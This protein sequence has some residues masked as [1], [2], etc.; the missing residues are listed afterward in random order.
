M[1]DEQFRALCER[2]VLLPVAT[3]EDV[4]DLRLLV[5]EAR[6]GRELERACR[7]YFH[8]D[9]VTGDAYPPRYL[10]T[11]SEDAALVT[12]GRLLGGEND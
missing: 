1:T 10:R 7:G 3:A 12:I 6:R 9:S 8:L 4:H 2:L 11:A 5:D